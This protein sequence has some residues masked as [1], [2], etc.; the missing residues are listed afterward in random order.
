VPSVFAT[1]GLEVALILIL[2]V[3]N[4]I[5][6]GSEIAIVSAR[7]LRL[8]QRAKQG[9]RQA[10][11]A[12]RLA[13]SPND[14]LSTVQIGITLIGILSGALGG[15]TLAEPLARVIRAVP[16]LR[17]WSEAISLVLVVSLITYLSLVIGELLP[18][19][20]ALSNPESIACAVAGPMRWLARWGSPLVR[21]LGWSTDGL[22]RLLGIGASS[23]PD[24]TEEEI[25]ALLRQGAETGVIEQSEHDLVQRLFHLADRPVRSIMTPRTEIKWVDLEASPA[26]QIATLSGSSHG[27]M[28][29]SRGS[30]DDCV[31]IL[32]SHAFLAARLAD[33]Q[34]DLATMLQPAFYVTESAGALA[35][36]GHFRETGMPIALVTDEYGGIEGLVTLTDLM[37]AIV[38]DLP[39]L[40]HPEDP[41]ALLREDGSWLLD[42]QI[43]LQEFRQRLQCPPLPGEESGTFH[44]L[45]GF[46][47][48]RFARVPR[49]GDHFSWHGLRFE[50]IDMDGQ[51]IDKVL[52]HADPQDPAVNIQA[53]SEPFS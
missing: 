25:H 34:V 40:E 35:V 46:V 17:P 23:E 10:A 24:L 38:G 44:T 42:G 39:S 47:L 13:N 16:P 37:E 48:H 2:I 33:D 20:I 14:F 8:E 1:F 22:M 50:V 15:A 53:G 27:R 30:L 32:R 26:E 43:D 51:R 29:V 4:G 28:P 49:A 36:I 19:R 6:S 7:K 21:L 3:A 5:F 9:N 12:L 11:M 45:A 52:V 31:G 41:P 18:K